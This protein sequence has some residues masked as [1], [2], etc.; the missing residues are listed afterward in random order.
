MTLSIRPLTPADADSVVAMHDDFL[1][2]LKS[3]G[4]PD[5]DV[6]EFTRERFL[7]DGFGHDPVFF[8]YLAASDGQACGYL[9]YC[10]GYNVDLAQRLFFICDLWVDPKQ[11][12][13]GVGRALVK[14]CAADC[15][16]WGGQW[17]E[18]YV[19][20][21]NTMALDFYRRLGGQVTDSLVIMS[22][23]SDSLL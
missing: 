5:G 22:A 10:K 3:L 14:K 4:D 11:R 9:L 21:P 17:L 19:Y 7:A 16:A 18:W 23:R 20:K 2:Y 13:G 15:K 6:R 1:A 12:R 8:G